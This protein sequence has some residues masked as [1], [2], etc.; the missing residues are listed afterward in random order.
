MAC[1]SCSNKA[2]SET[3]NVLTFEQFWRTRLLQF[4]LP[5]SLIDQMAPALAQT[6]LDPF[7][8]KNPFELRDIIKSDNQLF[9]Q[10]IGSDWWTNFE[11]FLNSLLSFLNQNAMNIGFII[12]GSIVV[13]LLRKTKINIGKRELPIG[14]FGLIP[15]IMG[16]IG[17]AQSFMQQQQGV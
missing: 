6:N 2:R 1:N 17:L 3:H 13:I 7:M 8:I 12:T 14:L 4:G 5:E 15:F 9:S 16:I 10:F 11:N